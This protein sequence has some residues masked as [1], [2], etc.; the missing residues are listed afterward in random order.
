METDSEQVA[1][2]HEEWIAAHPAAGLEVF[3][4]IATNNGG[5][6]IQEQSAEGDLDTCSTNSSE[7]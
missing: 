2:L 3:D 7:P 4:T 1:Y 5:E 6:E